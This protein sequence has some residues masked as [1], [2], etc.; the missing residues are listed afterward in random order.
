[1]QQLNK[2]SAVDN[3]PAEQLKQRI[4]ELER[5]NTE[6]KRIVSRQSQYQKAILNDAYVFFEVDLTTDTFISAAG[7]SEDGSIAD[8]F[9]FVNIPKFT[10]YSEFLQYWADNLILED[11]EKFLEKFDRAKLIECYESGEPEQVLEL[12]MLDRLRR[13]RFFQ[14]VMLIG[15]NDSTDEIISLAMAKDITDAKEKLRLFQMALQEANAANIAH[16][17]FLDNISHDVRTPLNSIIGFTELIKTNHTDEE[18]LMRYLDNIRISSRQ[19][20][21]IV[22]ETLELTHIES[23]KAMLNRV[24]CSLDE[25]ITAVIERISPDAVYKN[26]QLS[27]DVDGISEFDVCTDSIRL[28]EVLYQILDNAVKYTQKGGSVSLRC[29]EA[30]DS[31]DGFGTY[32]FE[33]HDTGCGIDEELI[34]SVFKPFSRVENSTMSGV[35]GSGLGLAVVKNIVDMMHGTIKVDSV[36]GK[37]SVFTVTLTFPLQALQKHEHNRTDRLAD[38]DFMKKLYILLVEDNPIN[39]EI[40]KAMLEHCGC[41]VDTAINGREA[42]DKV[43][44]LTDRLYDI[45]LMDIQMPVLDGYGAARAIRAIN[46]PKKAGIPIIAVSANAFEDDR[47]KSLKSG[48]NA[49]FPKPIDM[50]ELRHLIA[51]ILHISE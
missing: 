26:I 38:P 16:Q 37:G 27:Y 42:V 36:P 7:Q 51:R 34:Q 8:L 48:M 39:M 47:E 6:L 35:F 3:I 17:T 29:L 18:K 30:A 33:V 46:D 10:K 32:T 2:N 20:L 23:G 49:H 15:K 4:A 28:E 19:L 14:L 24:E 41:A 5:A 40:E 11:K 13:S 44:G 21:K 31:P 9:E 22:T 1:M 45:I 43:N 50:D 12:Q 25:L